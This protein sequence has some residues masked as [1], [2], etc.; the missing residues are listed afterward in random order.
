MSATAV[1]TLRGPLQ[2]W[3]DTPAATERRTGH[4]PT[5]S[6][7]VGMVAGAMG[8]R[9]GNSVEHLFSLEFG[10]RSDHV[11]SVV[12]DY[13][14]A[15]TWAADRPKWFSV[16]VGDYAVSRRHYL[17]DSAFSVGLSGDPTLVSEIA[18]ALRNPV[19]APVLG[20]QGAVPGVPVFPVNRA[21]FD[22]PLMAALSAEPWQ[23]PMHVQLRHRE[24]TVRL[25]VVRDAGAG[26]VPSDFVMDLSAS[27]RLG[28]RDFNPRPI[29]GDQVEIAVA[30]QDEMMCLR[31]ELFSGNPPTRRDLRVRATSNDLLR[32]PDPD[33]R[34][35]FQPAVSVTG[36]D[37]FS[38][39]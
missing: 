23:A 25:Q 5:K 32:V 35:V 26:E 8:L 33:V 16:P 39:L 17:E 21:V 7:V 30:S 1:L 6:A 22:G 36:H 14:V 4:R 37:P 38:V 28:E 19:L 9:S 10:V 29:V 34:R 15:R 24:P 11:G 20:R 13:Q 3:G 2:A 27:G 18:D 31:G 12:E